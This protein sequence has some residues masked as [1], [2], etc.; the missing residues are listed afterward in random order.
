MTPLRVAIVCDFAEEQWP[1][2][3]LVARMLLCFLARD[4]RDRIEARAI[5]PRFVRRLSRSGNLAGPIFNADRFINR[6]IDYPAVIRTIRDRF[7]LFHIIDHSYSHL[8][9]ELRPGRAVITCHDLDTFRCILDPARERRS[10][11]FRAMVRRIKH[12]FRKA[13]RICCVSEATRG[14]V[15]TH[16]L[17]PPDRTVTIPNGV[18]PAYSREPDAEGGRAADAI[19][20]L[21][22]E[23]AIDLLHVGSAISRKRLDLLLR[24]FAA[25]RKAFPAA[26]LVRVGGPF[27]PAQAALAARLGVADSIVVAPFVGARTLAAIYRRATLLLMPSDAEG[28]GLPVVEALACGTPVLASDLPAIREVAGEAVEYAPPGNF[29]AWI[30]AATALL[31]ERMH[32]PSR[33]V[34]RCATGLERARHFSWCEAARRTARLYRELLPECLPAPDVRMM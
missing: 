25:V 14:A 18:H 17:M 8:V 21:P 5:R 15:L 30:S 33:W 11:P 22:Y 23:G 28:F 13:A 6:F 1:S 4:H 3:D 19:L 9:H 12:G 31:E 24:T 10:E 7:D 27:T 20:G 32:D 34:T 16:R 29:E 2:M 26:R